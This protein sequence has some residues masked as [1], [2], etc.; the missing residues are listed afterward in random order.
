M[1]ESDE[2]Q[3]L[4]PREDQDDMI[5][6]LEQLLARAKAGQ[7]LGGALVFCTHRG[8]FR[9]MIGQYDRADMVF[10]LEAAKLGLV[11]E[12]FEAANADAERKR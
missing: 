3:V 9:R 8:V 12:G 6:A 4:L 2:P 7:L 1:T 10:A 11:L 5:E